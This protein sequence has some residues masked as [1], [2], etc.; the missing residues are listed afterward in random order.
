[1]SLRRLAL[2]FFAAAPFALLLAADGARAKPFTLTVIH[3]N[4]THAQH[5]PQDDTGDGGAARAA[6]VIRQIRAQVPNSLLLDAGDRFTGTLFHWK[7]RGLENAPLMNA[8]GFQAMTL[9]NHEFDEGPDGLANFIELLQF[10][11]VCA[12]LDVSRLPRLASRIRPDLVLTVGGQQVGIIGVTTVDARSGSKPGPD[13]VFHDDYAG[14]VQ[15]AVDRLA[16]RGVNK[17]VV[18]SHIGLTEDLKLAQAVSGVDLI[19]GGH[20]HTLLSKTYREARHIYPGRAVGKDGRTVYVVQAGGGD[21]RFVGR[22]DLEFDAEGHVT[23]ASGDTIL[24][25]RYITPAEDVQKEVERLAGPIRELK[26]RPIRDEQGRPV[27]AVVNLSHAKVRDEETPLAGLVADAMRAKAGAEVAVIAGGAI[28]DGFDAGA[29]ITYGTIYRVLPF[30]DVLCKITLKGSDLLEALEHGLSRYGGSGNGRFLQ[31]SGLRYRFDPRNPIGR[32]VVLV[33]I[34][35]RPGEF[36]PLEPEREYTVALDSY[37]RAG[38]DD[39]E[40]LRDRAIRPND[41]LGPVQDVFI[42]YIARHNPLQPRKEGRIV[43]VE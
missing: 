17:V 43:R 24:L 23:K 28:R 6:A 12:N 26:S 35:T 5:E 2:W 29:P 1:M 10:P 14:C 33:E 13:V 22:L 41:D 25:S 8:T 16:A 3:T 11:V 9:G 32:R 15:A 21:N 7:Y 31:V 27:T 19:V 39:Y 38:G 36:A 40:L 20:S 18:L 37:L 34:G 30:T 42:E 4:D